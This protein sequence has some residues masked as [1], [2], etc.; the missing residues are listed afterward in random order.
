MSLKYDFSVTEFKEYSLIKK[1]KEKGL[2]NDEFL[3]LLNHISLED[4]VAL[5]LESVIR[6]C[7]GK[8]FGF[9]LYHSLKS[10]VEK[11]VTN[12]A[13][14]VCPTKKQA[15]LFLGVLD[16]KLRDI[17]KKHDINDNFKDS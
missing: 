17:Y 1:Y 11:S 7:N 13:A 6:L 16:V 4:L 2:I 8:F 14:S 9:P 10:V 5:K 12:I 3:S 15:A